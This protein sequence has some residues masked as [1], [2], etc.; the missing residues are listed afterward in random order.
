MKTFV[1]VLSTTKSL[2]PLTWQRLTSAVFLRSAERLEDR[3]RNCSLKMRRGGSQPTCPRDS[4]SHQKRR[5]RRH[6]VG[7]LVRTPVSA[8]HSRDNWPSGVRRALCGFSDARDAPPPNAETVTE[9]RKYCEV[10]SS[11]SFPQGLSV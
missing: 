9:N 3:R 5:P 6:D 7:A 2:P 10:P 1:F 8:D 11:P 4:S